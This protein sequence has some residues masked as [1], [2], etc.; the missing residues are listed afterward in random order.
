MENI[1]ASRQKFTDSAGESRTR[2]LSVLVGSQAHGL[3]TP[4]SDSDYR[5]VFA[6][7][8]RTILSLNAKKEYK[9]WVEG[10]DEDATSY[11]LRHFLELALKCN[12]SILEVFSAPVQEPHTT[13][14]LD[15]G[16]SL[17]NLFQYIFFGNNIK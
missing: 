15:H 2:I 6:V 5:G 11:E 13:F 9:G 10:T 7:D 8:T 4:E 16:Q 14:E 3:A 1:K 12:P 17:K